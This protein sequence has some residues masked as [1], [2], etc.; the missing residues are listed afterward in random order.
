MADGGNKKLNF[1][2]G[3]NVYEGQGDLKELVEQLNKAASASKVLTQNL[4]SMESSTK[5]FGDTQKEANKDSKNNSDAQ[6]NYAK[7]IK[8][9]WDSSTI[10][11]GKAMELLKDR[12]ESLRK[13]IESDKK[14]V[15]DSWIDD[16]DI[17]KSIT[18]L[19]R[20]ETTFDSIYKNARS[21]A[22]KIEKYS[23]VS[24][25]EMTALNKR[26]IQER[27]RD[28]QQETDYR[29]AELKKQVTDFKSAMNSTG[30]SM[31]SVSGGSANAYLNSLKSNLVQ[32]GLQAVGIYELANAFEDLGREVI[33]VNYNT[34]NNQ[35]LMGDFS[36]ELRDSLNDSAIEMAK[37][38]GILVTD[39]QEIQGSWIRI[40]EA[41]AESPELLDKISMA[42]A[43]F[44][45]V[46]EIADAEEA[47]KLVNSTMLQF[48]LTVDEGV[49]TLNKWAYMADK[50]AMGTADEYGQSLSKIGG[51]MSSLNGDVDDAIVMT[52]LLGDRLAKSGDEAGNSL[53]TIL[54]YLTR[55]KT[56]TLFDK[57]AED[58]GDATLALKDAEGQF[59]D[60]SELMETTSRAYAMAVSTNN[61]TLAKSIQEAMGATRQGDVALTLLKNWSTEAPQYYQMIEESVDG[62]SSYLDEQ[63][64]ALMSTFQNQWNALYASITELG[65][66][67]G[68]AGVLEGMTTIM[69]AI[70]GVTDKVSELDP[71]VLKTV[72]TIGE[73]VVAFAAL[74]KIGEVTGLIGKF[75]SVIRT[76]TASQIAEAAAVE[77]S[78]QAY[79]DRAKALQSQ[80]GLNDKQIVQIGAQKR[81]FNLLNE[82]YRQGKITAVEYQKQL[83]RLSASFDKLKVSAQEEY[84]QQ[85]LNNIGNVEGATT[86]A[87]QTVVKKQSTAASIA[88]TVA[89]A[90]ETAAQQALNA[91]KSLVNPYTLLLA[92]ATAAYSVFQNLANATENQKQ[93]VDELKG[94]I[95]EL[96]DEYD[97]LNDKVSSGTASDGDKKRL[98]YL[99]VRIAR[100]K[101][102]LSIEEQKLAHDEIFGANIL[103]GPDNIKT[104]TERAIASLKSL[105]KEY[106]TQTN[107]VNDFTKKQDDY[108]KKRNESIEAGL[109]ATDWE[110]RLKAVDAQ[111]EKTLKKQSDA[112]DGII[113]KT[114]I[115][116]EQKKNLQGYLGGANLSDSDLKDANEILSNINEELSKIDSS[117]LDEVKREISGVGSA[118]E[119]AASKIEGMQSALS[120]TSS[121]VSTLSGYFEEYNEQGQ[122]SLDTVSKMLA[123][124]PEYAKYLVK[125]G[126][127]Y[128]LNT[129][130]MDDL[131]AAKD[132]QVRETDALIEA[133]EKESASI[134]TVSDSY[135][136]A[137]K[138]SD[139][140]LNSVKSTFSDVDGINRFVDA[141][142]D[143]NTKFLEGKTNSDEYNI[144][145]DNLIKSAD[146]SRVN[147]SL[148]GLDEKSKQ[149]VESQQAALTS[150]MQNVSGALQ[151]ATI[152]FQNGSIGAEEYASQL[153]STNQQ[154]LDMMVSTNGLHQD[155]NGMWVDVNG[156]TDAMA[157]NL[158]RSIDGIN[159][160]SSAIS[161]LT[162][163]YSVLSE[164]QANVANGT[165]DSAWWAAMQSSDA[166]A[167]MYDNFSATMGS[168]YLENN[169]A[170]QGIADTVASAMGV[171]VS[172]IFTGTGEIASGVG[173]SMQAV[174]AGSSAMID[175][176]GNNMQQAV[177]YG[178]GALESFGAM[179]QA[180][181]YKINLNAQQ[182]GTSHY[183]A[184]VLGIP[185]GF[186]I[187]N[188]ELSIA[189]NGD[190]NV[191]NF[192]KNLTS[193]GKTMSN[194][195]FSRFLNLGSFKP[196]YT[197]TGGAGINSGSYTPAP[198]S[199]PGSSGSSGSG[200]SGSGGSSGSSSSSSNSD[201]EKAAK[202]AEK[203]S[204]AAAK[205]A[206]DAAKA[207][208]KA[209][210]EAE[211][212]IENYKN[213]YTK[214]VE[215]FF[216]RTVSALKSK[217]QDLYDTR[218]KQLEAEKAAQIKVHDDRVSLLEDEIKRLEGNTSE[219][220]EKKLAG[221][222]DAYELWKNDNSLLGKSKQKE[223]LDQIAALEKDIRIDK[224]NEQIDSEKDAIDKINE[225]YDGLLDK[226][227][228]NY[229]PVLKSLDGMMTEKALAD[230]AANLIRNNKM[231]EIIDILGEY[232]PD[233]DNIA[234]LMGSTVG[235]IVGS[236]VKNALANYKDLVNNSITSAGG[237]NS[238]AAAS[239]S[240]NADISKFGGV[241][242]S[243]LETNKKIVESFTS[244]KDDVVL[245]TDEMSESVD[246]TF[247]QTKDNAND[248]FDDLNQD[249]TSKWK[250]IC[251]TAVLSQVEKLAIDINVPWNKMYSDSDSSFK[252]ISSNSLLI[253][254]SMMDFILSKTGL[255][256]DGVSTKTTAMQTDMSR[257]MVSI[258]DDTSS[259]MD[260][261]TN[262]LSTLPDKWHSEGVNMIT[263]FDEGIKSVNVAETVNLIVGKVVQAFT[264]G[265]V[266]KSPSHVMR[267]I[268]Q[269]VI[270]GL[271]NGLNGDKLFYIVD[272]LMSG[273]KEKFAQGFTPNKTG[274]QDMFGDDFNKVKDQ[275]SEGL[276]IN[277]GIGEGLATELA[278]GMFAPLNGYV[279]S[280]EFGNRESPGGIGSTNHQGMDL[281]AP[282]G[283]PIYAV[284]GGN[285]T[286][287][288]YYGGYGNA[289]II[290]HGDFKTLYGHMSSI[291]AQ[292]G[293]VSAGQ[294]IGYVG[295]TGNSTGPHLHFGVMDEGG[296]FIDPRRLMPFA[297]GGY[298]GDNEG[299]AYIDVKERILSA[300]QTQAFDRLVYDILPRI[301]VGN[302]SNYVTNAA[303]KSVVFNKELV[304]VRVDKVENHTK[305]DVDEMKNDLNNLLKKGLRKSGVKI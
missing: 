289:V 265:F 294:V 202:E 110:N 36:N 83:E 227:S 123:D 76:G 305:M 268:G 251:K 103:D 177:N 20:L 42:T 175:V 17:Q 138:V 137:I 286:L 192:A 116:V 108:S 105:N 117:V 241:D 91:V 75:T 5:K 269:F 267:D 211:K 30:S 204:Q 119:D 171:Q 7:V 259:R 198:I 290:D 113:E 300:E 22:D 96:S 239:S 156:A 47:V 21:S 188:L 89:T 224:L 50:T 180:F 78:T 71:A 223:L 244:M 242:A 62:T 148:D 185:L 69:S 187:P 147:E 66:A 38:T 229:D 193:L 67:I 238:N 144:S 2:V 162:D 106:E 161:F 220:K 256:V 84:A 118:S 208:Q 39:A 153:N 203:A 297:T 191:S 111:S 283:T 107:A 273:L 285:V 94:K 93:T 195:D 172:D 45:N 44:M 200:S 8:E 174:D 139:E 102:L 133:Q 86:E 157:N 257:K 168:L 215:S 206:E 222:K 60:F 218:K 253:W 35:R 104:Q 152:S 169:A 151:E 101:E 245:N 100:E 55:T 236:E 136:D 165:A 277:F 179:I 13:Q 141:L 250:D 90:A 19:K 282:E 132:E 155:I 146:F 264:D 95:G 260:E 129:L 216:S 301:D 291:A 287:A 73:L 63:N 59:K 54:A 4:S 219:D 249:A 142:Q 232:D 53:K 158:Q 149:V 33:K 74:K 166:Y 199:P 159:S 190:G 150:V 210:E 243:A 65:M 164:I 170:W 31:S 258:R 87:A 255:M 131:N 196:N 298:V 212:A 68:N 184:K 3:F 176:V 9:S 280:D 26:E 274:I 261:L 34:I 246:K 221:L 134:N 217:Y 127:Q 97:T 182:N 18:E 25:K 27:V 135:K 167:T 237:T 52:S 233:Y 15:G 49:E 254:Q 231:Q 70:A 281:A 46:G 81:A 128:K 85:I 295:S 32:T 247:V 205:A 299:V 51:Y 248:V 240:I 234:Y 124:H 275:L 145:I 160:V 284:S 304:S 99:E 178:S 279:I 194:M 181:S 235:E 6:S 115:L 288:D 28:A 92:G 80:N 10:S 1:G 56:V 12:A 61:D 271:I 37:N 121:T 98:E 109:N 24:Y 201:A 209:A 58:T 272:K 296:N 64:A 186:D 276:G 163:N 154:M 40:N 292:P 140:Y 252:N 130:A 82:Q 207:S 122:L 225:K 112:Y 302:S 173:L 57:I 213:T 228:E 88:N 189:G 14:A 72:L 293:P 43:K 278:N 114:K 263:S 197:P 41:Y 226:D 266:I 77:Q 48:N 29:K 120:E 126:D 270:Q 230:E 262:H 214:N 143:I 79:F 183:E 11:A 16:Q 303:N 23:A 125:E